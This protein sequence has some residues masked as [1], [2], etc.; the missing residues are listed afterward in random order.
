MP[1]S[2]GAEASVQPAGQVIAPAMESASLA[3][4]DPQCQ[5]TGTVPG[6][7]R[8]QCRRCRASTCCTCCL[9]LGGVIGRPAFIPCPVREGLSVGSQS[10][11][12]SRGC[13]LARSVPLLGKAER[14]D[15]TVLVEHSQESL[16]A[17]DPPQAG[18]TLGV[19]ESGADHLRASLG[20]GLAPSLRPL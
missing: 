4:P 6:P 13:A 5:P 16:R 10:V 19:P 11:A 8:C 9:S 1:G 2:L 17:R 15:K 7:Q 18:T 14:C 3:W 12:G 20:V